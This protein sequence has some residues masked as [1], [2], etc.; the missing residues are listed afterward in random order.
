MIGRSVRV[1]V[2]SVQPSGRGIWHESRV[3]RFDEVHAL[4]VAF[5]LLTPLLRHFD[6]LKPVV[7]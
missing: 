6:P 1:R 4:S 7:A 3:C 5:L 2:P